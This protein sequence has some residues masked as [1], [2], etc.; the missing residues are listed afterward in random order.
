[1]NRRDFQYENR[2]PSFSTGLVLLAGVPQRGVPGLHRHPRAVVAGNPA[3][4]LGD[5]KELGGRC[6]MAPEVTTGF[7]GEEGQG[8]VSAEPDPTE[9]EC[10]MTPKTIDLASGIR[11]RM[12]EPHT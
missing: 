5:A 10:T 6:R 7:K 8:T 12:K 9:T 11:T 4:S 3:G 1:M 2:H